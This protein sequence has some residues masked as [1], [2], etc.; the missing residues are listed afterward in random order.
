MAGGFRSFK[1]EKQRKMVMAILAQRHG[2]GAELTERIKTK[3]D[4]HN[5]QQTLN[6]VVTK[7]RRMAV[8]DKLKQSD[9]VMSDNEIQNVTNSLNRIDTGNEDNKNFAEEAR[10]LVSEHPTGVMIDEELTQKGLEFLTRTAI[11]KQLGEREK[12]VVD[13]FKEFQLVDWFDDFNGFR[14]FFQPQ[15]KVIANNDDSFEYLFTGSRDIKIVG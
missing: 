3:E 14:H 4:T 2:G 8:L 15:W 12:A 10:R 6:I 7:K 11:Q 9:V 5:T 13:N 1:S